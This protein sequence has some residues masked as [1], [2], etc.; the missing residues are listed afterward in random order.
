MPL[1]AADKTPLFQ[2]HTRMPL[3]SAGSPLHPIDYP[4]GEICASVLSQT[5]G[6]LLDRFF[7][8]KGRK[9]MAPSGGG[10][11]SIERNGAMR[12]F[13]HAA[14]SV[15]PSGQ[16]RHLVVLPVY[17]PAGQNARSTFPPGGV[18]KFDEWR[19]RVG[20]GCSPSPLRSPLP[21][22]CAAG[23]EGRDAANLLVVPDRQA[24]L[25]TGVDHVRNDAGQ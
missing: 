25:P 20:T 1:Q 10:R 8:W 7:G 4:N 22:D 24:P 18:S 9:A 3:H 12:H 6:R 19:S 2:R 11:C 13:C 5:G 15:Q 14:P 21:A 17:D 23:P 16:S